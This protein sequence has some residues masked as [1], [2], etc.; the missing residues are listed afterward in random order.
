[1]DLVDRKLPVESGVN[2]CKTQTDRE[3]TLTDRVPT[4]EG[5]Q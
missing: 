3:W 4:D 1:M 5:F 2:L